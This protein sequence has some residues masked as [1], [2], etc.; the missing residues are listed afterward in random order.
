VAKK[1]VFGNKAMPL[2]HIRASEPKPMP[3]PK[4]VSIRA[5]NGGFIVRCSPDTTAD[6]SDK[7]HAKESLAAAMEL[8]EQH[9]KG[10]K[11]EK[12]EEKD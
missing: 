1:G 8:A 11:P 12:K 6:Y 5:V 7:E 9:L 4:E 3:R 10:E 2:D